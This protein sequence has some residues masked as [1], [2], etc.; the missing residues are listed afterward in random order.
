M[1]QIGS[2]AYRN[3]NNGSIEK[4]VPILSNSKFD[5][6]KQFNFD[7][8]LKILNNK[9]VKNYGTNTINAKGSK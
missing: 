6:L 9:G 2:I 5:E 3:K 8:S 4:I 7:L 1:I